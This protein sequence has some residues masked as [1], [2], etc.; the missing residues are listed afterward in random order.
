MTQEWYD[1]KLEESK[2]EA[3]RVKTDLFAR[4]KNHPELSNKCKED[5][6]NLLV[7]GDGYFISTFLREEFRNVVYRSLRNDNGCGDRNV[8][9]R[10][11]EELNVD[12]YVNIISA[13]SN[14]SRY[15]DSEYVSF[16]GDII[17]TDPCYIMRHRDESTRP[18]WEDYMK[19]DDYSGMTRE[20]ME[21]VGFFEDHKRLKEAD[22]QWE[23]EHPDDWDICGCGYN[24]SALGFSKSMVRDTL[25][26]DWGC[27][28]FNVDTKEPIGHFCADSGQ[29]AVFHLADVLAYN[30]EYNDHIERPHCVTLIKNF[31]G[32]VRFVVKETTGVY[33][34]DTKWWKA[35]NTWTEYT[36][37]V[38]GDGIDTSTGLRICFETTQTSL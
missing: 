7:G 38:I 10:V 2:N 22:R 24:M 26:G 6:Q 27:T 5:L 21:D 33:K 1:K 19:L 35:G 16:D 20:E 8:C 14:V 29:V 4:I 13:I 25:Y 28:T 31:K 17:I 32:N 11:Y 15:L 3:I 37:H 23:E 36:V 34:S 9:V 30:T 18:K 12:D